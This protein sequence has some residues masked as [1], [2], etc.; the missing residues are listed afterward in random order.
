MT[1][2]LCHSW[3]H[4][5]CNELTKDQYDRRLKTTKWTFISDFQV[6]GCFLNIGLPN[7]QLGYLPKKC[8]V[9]LSHLGIRW[10][11]RDVS[12]CGVLSQRAL[13]HEPPQEKWYQVLAGRPWVVA[14]SDNGCVLSGRRQKGIL[15]TLPSCDY[16]SE[17]LFKRSINFEKHTNVHNLSL[18]KPIAQRLK[19]PSVPQALP[20]SVKLLSSELVTDRS[21]SRYPMSPNRWRSW[22]WSRGT[23][24]SSYASSSWYPNVSLQWKI[25]AS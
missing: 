11:E 6:G 21:N 22:G 3:C 12:S 4:P 8:F 7:K 20:P 13:T 9:Y 17:V 15:V 2:D 5:N 19:K 14:P 24:W 10:L 23:I 25:A 16:A 1:C 18:D